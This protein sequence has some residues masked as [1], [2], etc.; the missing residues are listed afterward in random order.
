MYIGIVLMCVDY[1]LALLRIVQADPG[2]WTPS[3]GGSVT[4]G[5]PQHPHHLGMDSSY[6]NFIVNHPPFFS[7]STDPLEVDN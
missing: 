1:V 6:S 2:R 5:H 3:R 7:E 4:V